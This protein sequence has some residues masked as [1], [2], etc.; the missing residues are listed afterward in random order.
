VID[1]MRI[2]LSARAREIVLVDGIVVLR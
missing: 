1:A 2:N